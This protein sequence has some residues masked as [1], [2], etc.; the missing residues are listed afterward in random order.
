M[1]FVLIPRHVAAKHGSAPPL[2]L[3]EHLKQAQE[4]FIFGAPFASLALIRSVMEL[5]LRIHYG[6]NGTLEHQINSVTGLP[7]GV[8][9]YDLHDIQD[10]AN[11]V[12]HFRTELVS[13]PE[14]IERQMV[15]HLGVLQRLIEGAPPRPPASIRRIKR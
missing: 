9:R 2:S 12:L 5:V 14:D 15:K 11:D 1:P 8:T 6:T 10:L 4:A 7:A 3:F 13:M